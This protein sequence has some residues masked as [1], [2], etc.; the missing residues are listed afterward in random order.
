MSATD[1]E[2]RI[3]YANAAFVSISGYSIQELL[4]QPH[5]LVR[6]PDMPAAAFADMW[7]TLKA[8]LSWTGL[9]KNRCKNGDF[10]WV[11][12]NVSPMVRDGRLV[13]CISVRTKPQNF[14]AQRCGGSRARRRAGPWLCGGG[15]RSAQPGAA[16]R[17]RGQ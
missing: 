17:E 1:L 15:Q 5:K 16:Q 9:V 2:S 12:A 4:G 11:R 6:H 10:Y 14:G 8:G 7:A 13:G 3:T